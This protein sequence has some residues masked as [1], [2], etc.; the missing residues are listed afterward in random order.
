MHVYMRERGAGNQQPAHVSLAH[1]RGFTEPWFAAC[2]VLLRNQSQ[3]SCKIPASA[4]AIQI[5]PKALH[6]QGCDWPRAWHGLSSP[7]R[8]ND[9][10]SVSDIVLLFFYKRLHTAWCN[11]SHRMAELLNLAAPAIGRSTG[12]HRNKARG[13]LAH[14]CK[15]LNT[16][17]FLAKNNRY[18]CT[19]SV[20]LKHAR[21]NVCA[22][23]G[24]F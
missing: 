21:C 7:R 1:L 24:D 11:Q 3:P 23:H 17:H 13:V 22:D 10:F 15:T 5:R 4:K 8:F 2:R 16:R 18:V 9:G 12:H 19:S 6:C 14:K 20:K